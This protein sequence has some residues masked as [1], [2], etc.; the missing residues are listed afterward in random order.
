MTPGIISNF[1][2]NQNKSLDY[3]MPRKRQILSKLISNAELKKQEKQ[4]RTFNKIPTP[5]I[6]KIASDISNPKKNQQGTIEQDLERASKT[7]KRD[8]HTCT[9]KVFDKGKEIDKKLA[10]FKLKSQTEELPKQSNSIKI[11]NSKSTKK[12]SCFLLKCFGY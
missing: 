6:I 12:S 8:L 7:P 11:S 5:D 9:E 10:I 2:S 1:N 4:K 3:S